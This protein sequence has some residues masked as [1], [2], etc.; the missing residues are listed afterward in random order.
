MSKALLAGTVAVPLSRADKPIFL[1]LASFMPSITKVSP[2]SFN[3]QSNS[4]SKS[5]VLV[6][7]HCWT[8]CTHAQANCR[9][10]NGISVGVN[11]GVLV[12]VS[13]GVLVGVFVGVSVGVGVG[14]LVGV[15]VGVLV[16]VLVYVRVGVSEGWVDN[17][18]VEPPQL[19]IPSYAPGL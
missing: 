15:S 2:A 16:G 7:V 3:S 10:A 12:G 19:Y 13:V 4:T 6:T 5:L 17:V 8:P 14:V 18:G 1:G 11:V 9:S